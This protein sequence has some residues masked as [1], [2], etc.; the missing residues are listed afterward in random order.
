[1]AFDTGYMFY[2]DI[3][4]LERER[5]LLRVRSPLVVDSLNF[6]GYD[7][8]NVGWMDL[9]LPEVSKG[10]VVGQEIC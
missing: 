4:Q 1:M 10:V 3:S 6:M 5:P 8:A 9:L 2:K 7:A